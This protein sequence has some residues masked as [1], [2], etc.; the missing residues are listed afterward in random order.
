MKT[1]NL[2]VQELNSIEQKSISGG[3]PVLAF[4]AGAILGGAVYDLWKILCT[5]TIEV[6][7]EHPEYYDGPVHSQF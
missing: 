4:I 5:E 2:L 7:M 1:E 3:N 6:Q